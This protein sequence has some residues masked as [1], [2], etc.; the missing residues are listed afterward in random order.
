MLDTFE[1]LWLKF[2]GQRGCIL[3]L[4][5]WGGLPSESVTYELFCRELRV[6]R[7]KT[8]GVNS[9]GTESHE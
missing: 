1:N 3:N 8:E 6:P 9:L 4:V 2:L 5:R 7:I